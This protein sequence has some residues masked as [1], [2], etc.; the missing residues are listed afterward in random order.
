VQ[1]YYNKRKLVL[2][3]VSS[4][5]K[6]KDAA[7]MPCVV[8]KPNTG[9]QP[10]TESF[11]EIRKR[12]RRVMDYDTARYHWEDLYDSSSACCL[13]AYMYVMN[14]CHL[15]QL[16]SFIVDRQI[17]TESQHRRDNYWVESD[18]C[19][20]HISVLFKRLKWTYNVVHMVY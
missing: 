5:A 20:A 10:R 2:L 6:K 14:V 8:Y 16:H 9:R 3:A 18:I 15:G 19:G 13:H 17:V 1:D 12:Y 4:K 7:A 11:T